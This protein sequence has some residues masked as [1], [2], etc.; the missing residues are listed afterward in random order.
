MCLKFC[1]D[2]RP[3]NASSI[4]GAKDG[5]QVYLGT[6]VTCTVDGNPAPS[7][8][9]L[10]ATYGNTTNTSTIQIWHSGQYQCTAWNTA[11]SSSVSISVTTYSTYILNSFTSLINCILLAL[12]MANLKHKEILFEQYNPCW[13]L[14]LSISVF[15]CVSV[16]LS[17]SFFL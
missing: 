3:A 8:S 7:Y 16:S 14:S 5:D 1:S 6:T 11:G 9:W 10:D 13:Y 12:Q 17:N 15:R 2:L 4:T